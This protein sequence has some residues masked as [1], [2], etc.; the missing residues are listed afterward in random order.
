MPEDKDAVP[1]EDLATTDLHVGQLYGSITPGRSVDPLSRMLRVGVQGGIR[2]RGQLSRGIARLVALYSTRNEPDWPDFLDE[3]TGTLTYFG[4]NRDPARDLLDTNLYGNLI[5]KNSFAAAAGNVSDRAGVPPFFYFERVSDKGPIVRFRGL[6]VPGAPNG[7]EL[8][9]LVEIV[10]EGKRGIVRNYRARFTILD[11]PH[12]SRQWIDALIAGKS[13]LSDG[14]PA[15][16]RKWV[17]NS[18]IA[19]EEIASKSRDKWGSAMQWHE[20]IDLDKAE[21]SRLVTIVSLLRRYGGL[22]L[23]GPTGSG[24]SWFASQAADF[25]TDNDRS[26]QAYVQFHPSYQFEDFMEGYRPSLEKGGFGYRPGLFKQ[27]ATEARKYPSQAYVMVIDEINRADTARVFGEAFTY[28]DRAKRG[29]TFLLPSGDEFS[30][31]SNMLLIATM[32]PV[33]LGAEM[34][35]IAFDRRFAQMKIGYDRE[36]LERKLS[37]GILADSVVRDVVR[38]VSR[39]NEMARDVPEAEIGH[40]F[41]FHVEDLESLQELWDYQLEHHIR[42]VFK[43]DPEHRE[44]AESRWRRIFRSSGS[45]ESGS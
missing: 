35:D 22:I 44:E 24:K 28:I 29:L 36:A 23:T 9:D 7:P 1:V 18:E 6:A 30:V 45:E 10:I 4:D 25:L 32:N 37:S 26:R 14:C 15:A 41:F 13:T 31:P 43:F 34:L 17:E 21:D 12:V 8:G 38:W 27:I 39:V 11:T 40:G 16:W 19:S 33:D 5:F 42:R 2:G 20:S 3:R